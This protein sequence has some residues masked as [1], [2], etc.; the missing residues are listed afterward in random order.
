MVPQRRPYQFYDTAVSICATCLRRVDAKIVFQD[1]GVWM[2]KRC[3]THGAERVLIADDIDYYK[4]CREVFVKTPEQVTRYNTRTYYGCP[5]DCGIC[6]DHE[7]HGCILLIEITDA[8]NLRCPTCYA[9]SGPERQTHR[10]LKQIERMLDLAVRN[11]GEPNIVQI[12]GGEPTIHPRFFEILDAARRRPIQHLMVN[13]NG[14]RIAREEDFAKRLKEYVPRFEIYLQFDS[15]RRE[16]LEILRAADTRRIHER[17]L[18]R[19]ND[20]NIPTTLVVTVRRGVN[21]DELGEIIEF[22][23]AQ[24]CVRGVTFQPV[25]A[26]GRLDGYEGGFDMSRDRLTLTEVRRRILEQSDVFAPEDII[27]VPCHSE[28]LAM[29]YGLKLDDR[30]M[31]LTGM[32]DPELL[33]E[34]GRNTIAYEY[35][36]IV[37]DRLFELFSTHHSPQSQAGAMNDFLSITPAGDSLDRLSYDNIFRVLIVQFIDAYSFDLRSIRKT[38][39]HIVH[40]DGKRAIPFDT[41][42]MFYRDDLEGTLLAE[43]RRE[44]EPYRLHGPISTAVRHRNIEESSPATRKHQPESVEHSS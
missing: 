12:S 8:C 30:F 36:D 14:I 18:H 40:P 39:V 5:Y 31:P 29:A 24:P 38:C 26:A 33:I 32:V 3:P 25:Q 15:F 10:S 1:G 35:E 21:D 41:Y 37:R 16:A 6:P 43:I 42:N 4:R 17:A 13:T 19:L 20:L 44:R 23:L 11:E 7:Q 9:M 28:S 2:L 27:P 34:G 22:A